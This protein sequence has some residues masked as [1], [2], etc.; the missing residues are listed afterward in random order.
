MTHTAVA[1]DC[2]AGAVHHWND[3]RYSE[4]H[5]Q[6]VRQCAR[7][8]LLSNRFGEP[9]GHVSPDQPVTASA[10]EPADVRTTELPFDGT[11]FIEVGVGDLTIAATRLRDQ[12]RTSA[13]R[14]AA[15]DTLLDFATLHVLSGQISTA[16]ELLAIVRPF[17]REDA[18]RIAR[19]QS[20]S[21]WIAQQRYGVFHDGSGANAVEISARWSGMTELQPM[22]AEWQR[23]MSMVRSPDV[24]REC[25]LI[26]SFLAQQPTL[27]Y[28]ASG[29]RDATSRSGISSSHSFRNHP[30]RLPTTRRSA[31]CLRS[32]DTRTGRKRSS[33]VPRATWTPR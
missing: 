23:M 20:L 33:T 6:A 18:H 25:Q 22:D 14:D 21:L 30:A 7:C 2:V 32:P 1:T 11:L 17:V 31:I 3:Y 19:V 12:L 9:L 29:Q 24:R 5:A 8:G 10:T 4:T 13:T 26:Y 27:R 16:A 15:T 28:I